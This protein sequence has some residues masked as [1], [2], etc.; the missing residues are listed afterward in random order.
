MTATNVEYIPFDRFNIHIRTAT[1]TLSSQLAGISEL[2]TTT[3]P[4]NARNINWTVDQYLF[5]SVLF[6]NSS[7]NITLRS[8]T[9]FKY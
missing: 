1:Q 3:N 5:P 7:E 9:I 8:L 2:A 4:P 6:T